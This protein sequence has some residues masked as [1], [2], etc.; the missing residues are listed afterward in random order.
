MHLNVDKIKKKL[1]VIILTALVFISSAVL[2]IATV[3]RVREVTVI[4]S[5]VSTEAKEEEQAL[6]ARLEEAYNKD[7]IFFANEGEAEKILEE[8]PY[9][10]I[11]SFEKDYL[12]RI[13]IELTEDA[14][15]YAVEAGDGEYYILSVN[16]TVLEKRA[17]SQNRLEE[18]ENLIITGLDVSGEKGKKLNG[19]ET[20]EAILLF[21][22][23]MSETLDGLRNNVVSLCVEKLTQGQDASR[24]E[25]QFKIQM[26]EGVV[27]Y[28]NLPM[29]RTVDKA[30]AAANE[31]MKLPDNQKIK[32]ELRVFE[33][34][35]DDNKGQICVNYK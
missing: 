7:S 5:V 33:G 35:G 3:Y 24:Q 6:K 34:T 13:V 8:F 4:A 27:I 1:I 22:N 9:F 28:V 10:Q 2:G 25:I 21:C 20:L 19:G 29:E 11:T 32:G 16:G 30:I 23:Q 26:V 31:Y 14:E 17:S 15:V 18:K 12:N